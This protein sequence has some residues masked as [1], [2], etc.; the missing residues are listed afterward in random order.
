[1]RWLE[2]MMVTGALAT[3]ACSDDKTGTPGADTASAT[4][5]ADSAQATDSAATSEDVLDAT[6]ESDSALTDS[7]VTPDTVVPVDTVVD[8]GPDIPD[9][10]ISPDP[11]L[12]SAP[13]GDRN[14]YDLQNPDCADHFT[15]EPV[16]SPGVFVSL[17]GVVVTGVFGD[18]WFVEDPR[19]GPYSGI[20][21]FNHGL[22]N[23]E[24][25][26]GD[27]LDVDGNYYEFF[28]NS[29]VYL[30]KATVTGTAAVPAPFIIE[31][32]SYVATDGPLAEMFEGVL[33]KVV[34]VYT[35]HTRPDCPQEYGEFEVSG[36]LR[37]DDLGYK[38]DARLGDHFTSITGPLNYTFG[39]HKIEPR[40]ASDVVND[41]K[42]SSS[43]I[44]KCIASE[45]QADASETGTRAVIINEVMADPQGQDT[46]Q[47]WIELYNPGTSG[48]DVNGW[49]LRDCGDQAFTLTGA[50]LV[51]PAKGYLVVGANRN[52]NLNG[53]VPVDVAYGEGF[54]LPNTVGS[55]LLYT[56]AT[57]DAD[58]VDQ[59]RYE[60]F[61]P[62]NFTSGH[63]LERISPTSDGTADTSWKA[64]KNEFG[65]NGNYGTPGEKNTAH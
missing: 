25:A 32:G 16:G 29:Q 4:D 43:G 61:A 30:T 54:Y 52:D 47:E 23:G 15:P 31:Y 26:V 13:G 39:N 22:M 50:D 45:C 48:V 11:T 62:W 2:A 1:M 49:Q 20:L 14:I 42:G 9:P 5:A 37:I 3:V 64:A 17:S 24:V 35:T 57:A 19:G 55:V 38:W 8:T 21:V 56:G 65:T 28:E 53:G 10:Q 27:E 34:D 44:S 12:C 36:K 59:M 51:I 60:R 18:T 63:S 33:V 46:N 6:T 41:V 40:D 7:A 58:L